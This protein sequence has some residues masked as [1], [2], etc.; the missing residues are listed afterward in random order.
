MAE[1]SVVKFQVSHTNLY[2]FWETGISL[3]VLY[4]YLGLQ[5]YTGV[6]FFFPFEMPTI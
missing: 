5:F 6:K 1:K 2:Q 3:N 4:E